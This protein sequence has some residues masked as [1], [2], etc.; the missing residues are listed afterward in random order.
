MSLDLN[1]FSMLLFTHMPIKA[2]KIECIHG[3][4]LIDLKNPSL[5]NHWGKN[6][7]AQVVLIK[8]N[9]SL[10]LSNCSLLSALVNI[11]AIF[12][13]WHKNSLKLSPFQHCLSKNNDVCQ[14][15]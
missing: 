10:F 9:S 1:E 3:I 4:N 7:H 2:Q 12:Y 13:Q 5:V 14:Y 11:S 8:P 6:K 15:A